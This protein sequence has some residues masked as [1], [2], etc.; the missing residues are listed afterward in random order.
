MLMFFYEKT[1]KNLATLLYLM[2]ISLCTQNGSTLQ[3]LNLYRTRDLDLE[4]IQNIV[5]QCTKVKEINF[6]STKLCGDTLDFL[7]KNLP[8]SIQKI[9]LRNLS[10]TDEHVSELV[11][12]YGN[13]GCDLKV[14]SF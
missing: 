7:V 3:L 10:L 6:G 8:H 13:L 2:K 4:A 9:S 5:F 14:L 1:N 11:Q 12:R